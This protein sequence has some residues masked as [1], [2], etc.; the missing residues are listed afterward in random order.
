MIKKEIIKTNN[1]T[2]ET[3]NIGT[4]KFGKLNLFYF[5]SSITIIFFLSLVVVPDLF[6]NFIS[7]NEQQ[8]INQLSVMD[9]Q[10]DSYVTDLI[11]FR[12][13]VLSK[14][15]LRSLILVSIVLVFLFLF[16]K[17]KISKHILIVSIGLI[18]LLDMW[19]VSKRYLNNNDHLHH[20]LY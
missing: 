2:P 14:D 3:P 20:H 15:S 5:L 9:P 17:N 4:I 7:K 19:G 13:G 18:V 8:I 11:N 16:I 6:L 12:I 10:T 1:E